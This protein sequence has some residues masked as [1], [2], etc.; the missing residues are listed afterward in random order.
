[1]PATPNKM[2]KAAMKARRARKV[3][4]ERGEG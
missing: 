3:R 2:G 1:M 4:I